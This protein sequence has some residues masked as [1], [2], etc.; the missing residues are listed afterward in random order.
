MDFIVF[1]MTMVLS[2]ALSAA[3]GRLVLGLVLR[4]LWRSVERPQ[5]ARVAVDGGRA[6]H[7]AQLTPASAE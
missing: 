3:A 4:A 5:T 2:V 1:A 6:L 7:T